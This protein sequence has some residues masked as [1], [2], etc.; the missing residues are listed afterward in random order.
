MWNHDQWRHH[1]FPGVKR[2]PKI[3]QATS[4]C[5]L[6][7]ISTSLKREIHVMPPSSQKRRSLGNVLEEYLHFTLCPSDS[8]WSHLS[9]RLYNY[10]VTTG[11]AGCAK[12][13]RMT[14]SRLRTW[15]K[16]HGKCVRQRNVRQDNE[17]DRAGTLPLNLYEPYTVLKAINWFGGKRGVRGA[18]CGKCGV[19]KMR[20]VENAECGKWGVWKMSVWN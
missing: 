5:Q 15:V 20:G 11:L 4:S 16:M 2:R 10:G 17:I 13:E 1:S 9:E 18:E 14:Y 8:M 3:A 12:N 19:W 7:S 6:F